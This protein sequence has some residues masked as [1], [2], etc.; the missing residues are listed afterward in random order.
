MKIILLGTGTSCGVPQ[1]GCNCSVCTSRDK[2]DNRLRCSA[3]VET[4]TTRILIDCGPDFREQM[5]R[6]NDFRRID[7]VLLTHIHFD[8]VGGLDD[9]RPFSKFGHIAVYANP[10][11]AQSLN[12][13]MPYL[14][15]QHKYPGIPPIQVKKTKLHKKFTIGD[16]DITPIEVMHGSLPISGYRLNDTA[17][18][19]D[20][21]TIADGELEYLK[22]VKTMVVNALRYQEHPTHQTVEDAIAFI[23]RVGSKRN[24]LI[25]MSHHI[26]LHAEQNKLLPRGI[27][28]GYDGMVIKV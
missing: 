11:T 25:H 7:A 28:L 6:L 20:M 8:H 13:T 27:K 18:I 22:G 17:Y 21:K 16:I 14:F 5:L 23:R 10:L 24:Y 26:G 12:H 9:L 1:I 15:A 3:I 2:H 4:E 19:T